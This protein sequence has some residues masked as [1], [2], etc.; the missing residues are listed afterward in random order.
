MS[1]AEFEKE[2]EDTHKWIRH[3]SEDSREK[4]KKNGHDISMLQVFITILFGMN[5]FTWIYIWFYL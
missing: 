5:L 1:K 2:L 4:F 3:I